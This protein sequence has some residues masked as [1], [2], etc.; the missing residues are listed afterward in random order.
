MNIVFMG[1]KPLS[2][3][4]LRHLHTISGI[5]IV[6]VVCR[7]PGYIGWWSGDPNTREVWEEASHLH[8]PLIQE[9]DVLEIEVDW[10]VSVLYWKRIPEELLSHSTYGGVNLHLA[11]LPYYRGCNPTSHA[12]LN[13]EKQYGVTLHQMVKKIDEG[14]IYATSCWGIK[15][16][17]TCW[18]LY[19]KAEVKAEELFNMEIEDVLKKERNPVPQ[20]KIAEEWEI[21]NYHRDSLDALKQIPLDM[22]PKDMLLRVRALSFPGFE[23]PY[24][25]LEGKKV[26]L[27]MEWK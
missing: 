11:M 16:E 21:H 4:C 18:S 13:Q 12:I 6:G 5:K 14:P 20:G 26:Y 8:I 2:G 17:D 22:N 25:L 19:K 3:Q 7:E 9:K 1:G 27:S 24:F 10:I 15:A 23:P